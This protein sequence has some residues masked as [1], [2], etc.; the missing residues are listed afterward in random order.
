MSEREDDRID[1][2]ITELSVPED[3]SGERGPGGGARWA[4]VDR[5]GADR[6][7]DDRDEP[8]VLDD[9]MAGQGSSDDPEAVPAEDLMQLASIRDPSLQGAVVWSEEVDRLGEIT[10]VAVYQGELEARVAGQ[11]QPDEADA[12]N[13]ELLIEGELREGETDDAGEAAEEGLAWVPPVDPPFVAGDDGQPEI[14]AGFGLT[15][16]E[17]PFDADHHSS[18]LP[19]E[20]ERTERVIEALRSHAET[21][22]LVDR[23]RVETQGSR[24]IVAGSVDDLQDEDAVLGVIS[25]VDG[26]ADVVNRIEVTAAE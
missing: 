1:A 5:R 22:G 16:D 14:A 20:D 17:E 18:P 11:D 15:A 6:G 25:E 23:L 4:D 12:Q 10:D 24:V 3:A 26:V 19:S 13:L 7:G 21:V 2:E 9:L 8:H